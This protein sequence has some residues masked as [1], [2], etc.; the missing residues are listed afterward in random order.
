M[1]IIGWAKVVQPL[2]YDRNNCMTQWLIGIF[3]RLL[4]SKDDL[5]GRKQ[6]FLYLQPPTVSQTVEAMR[7][8]ENELFYFTEFFPAP[9]FFHAYQKRE[10][11]R[12][13]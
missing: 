8:R 10:W 11:D 5:C 1:F 2:M 3:V 12:N 7:G 13:R 6:C 4:S 9:V